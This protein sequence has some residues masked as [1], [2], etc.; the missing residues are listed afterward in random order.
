MRRLQLESD[1]CSDTL[2]LNSIARLVVVRFFFG[3]V[4]K[5]SD[6]CTARLVTTVRLVTTARLVQD[7]VWRETRTKKLGPV[8]GLC[9]VYSTAC[10]G[11]GGK[12][13]RDLCMRQIVMLTSVQTV[14][15]VK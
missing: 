7:T 6:R 15:L 3:K 11:L 13:K 9:P 12:R 4:L 8:Y 1:L 14:R 2:L 5:S 10:G